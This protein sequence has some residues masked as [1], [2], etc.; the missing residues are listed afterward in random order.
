M[1]RKKRQCGGTGAFA[2]LELPPSRNGNFASR[3]PQQ[4]P[5]MPVDRRVPGR[6]RKGIGTGEGEEVL[7]TGG[8]SVDVDLS[9]LIFGQYFGQ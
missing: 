4:G 9:P 2:R 8:G 7:V 5:E 1:F 6:V 3:V